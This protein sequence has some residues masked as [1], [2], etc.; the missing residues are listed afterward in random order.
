MIF[1][2]NCLS[3][4]S[5]KM[6]I[7]TI[8]H[9]LNEFLK[10][11]SC[12]NKGDTVSS[13]CITQISALVTA[14]QVHRKILAFYI[15]ALSYILLSFFWEFEHKL[16]SLSSQ[17]MPNCQREERTIIDKECLTSVFAHTSSGSL[18]DRIEQYS[19]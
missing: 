14:S 15:S 7:C 11:Q 18:W 12:P 17:Y 8:I 4:H 10:V 13:C 2:S 9:L 5:L 19:E 16:G 1:F 6:P 3:L